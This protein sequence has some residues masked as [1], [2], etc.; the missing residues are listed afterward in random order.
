MK[1]VADFEEW[2]LEKYRQFK[3][4]QESNPNL[5][6][7]VSPSTRSVIVINTGNGKTGFSKCHPCDKFNTYVGYGIAWAKYLGEEIPKQAIPTTISKLTPGERFVFINGIYSDKK[8]YYIGYDPINDAA[9][10]VCANTGENHL[11]DLNR[12]VIKI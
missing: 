11:I 3:K 9:V 10:A 1:Y 7:V 6:S 12:H 4:A 8:F 2:A 5:V